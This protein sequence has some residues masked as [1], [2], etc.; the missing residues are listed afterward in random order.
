[1]PAVDESPDLTVQVDD[2]GLHVS[3]VEGARLNVFLD[4]RR[5]WSCVP[6]RD[7]Q[8]PRGDRLVPWPR[9][10]VPFLDG[11]AVVDVEDMVSGTRVSL[12]V[13]FGSG[14]GRVELRDS[15]GHELVVDKTGRLKRTFAMV[16]DAHR[17]RVVEATARALDLLR[18][19]GVEA[20]LTY[21]CLLGAVRDGRV[22]GH[23]D[24]A[25]ISYLA[26]AQHPFDVIRESFELERLY[27]Q[28][29]W[30]TVRLSGADFK[31]VTTTPGERT[32]AID[33][34]TSFRR[35]EELHMMPNVRAVLPD[36]ALLP[37]GT[38][39][40]EG[41]ELPAPADPAA[42]LEAA[43]G[44]DWR[45]PDPSFK[46]GWERD[47]RRRTSGWMRGE[48]RNLSFWKDHHAAASPPEPSALARWTA[49]REDPTRVL[50]VGCGL[51]SDAVYLAER[52]FDVVGLDY[53]RIGLDRAT[54]LAAEHDVPARFTFLN[55][56]DLRYVLARAALLAR[57]QAPEVVHAHLLV[58]AL[59]ADG[60]ENFWRFC[61]G[62]LRRGGRVYL[63]LTTR[64]SPLATGGNARDW[65]G[66]EQLREELAEHGFAVTHA[67]DVPPAPGVDPDDDPRV[68][69]LVATKER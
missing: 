7:G 61:R 53:S 52:G 12:E 18:E 40:L 15:A 28:H 26:R 23:D 64:P 10:M 31:V 17:R 56:Y 21:G 54:A 36:S 62:S 3:S 68:H 9:Q 46:P 11:V 13:S 19:H 50:D 67:E 38:V 44:P 4:G 55:L 5:V 41:Q 45:V 57:T 42:V 48:R 2:D 35:G 34:F 8:G 37:T 63:A 69:R 20:F 60:R 51:G 32:I 24:D 29:G 66:P 58:D 33:V 39:T 49:D 27:R 16:S 1:M 30:R 65:P 6:D 59:A 14:A 43:Y 25:D 47:A 22:I